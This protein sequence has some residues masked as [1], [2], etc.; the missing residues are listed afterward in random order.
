[1]D[2][3]AVY[4]LAEDA[5]V[6]SENAASLS[7]VAAE[8]AVKAE[9]TI[10]AA[11]LARDW[12]AFANVLNE[13]ASASMARGAAREAHFAAVD[14]ATAARNASRAAATEAAVA[15]LPDTFSDIPSPGARSGSIDNGASTNN[16]GDGSNN[17]SMDGSR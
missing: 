8:Q 14:K 16:I 7:R 15:N 6:A 13:L 17:P 4:R 10:N 9:D 3:W 2:P 12:N 5:L 11:I 1:M